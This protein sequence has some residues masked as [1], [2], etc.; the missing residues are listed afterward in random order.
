MYIQTVRCLKKVNSV[1]V[2]SDNESGILLG[3]F[4]ASHAA[5]QTVSIQLGY[6]LE[7]YNA[8]FVR[9]ILLKTVLQQK[10]PWCVNCTLWFILLIVEIYHEICSGYK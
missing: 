6:S 10:F 2:Q 3:V 7:W 4:L 9:N 1:L 8:W 5:A